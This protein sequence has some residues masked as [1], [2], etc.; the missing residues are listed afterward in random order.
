MGLIRLAMMFMVYISDENSDVRPGQRFKTVFT[1]KNQCIDLLNDGYFE[2]IEPGPLHSPIQRFALRRDETLALTLE[3]EAAPNA[4]STAVPYPSGTVRFNTNQAELV[5]ISG[6]RAVL[7]GVQTR[8]VRRSGGLK[9]IA[10]VH[11]LTATPGDLG[12]TAY[13]IE[14]LENVPASPFFWPDSIRT[15]NETATTSVALAEDCI[16]I[17]GSDR[18][19]SISQAA[20]RLTVAGNTLYLCTFGRDDPG[21]K[22]KSGCV[23]YVGTPDDLT[24]KKI[25][26]ALGFALG[27]Y[28]IEIGHTLYDQ[29]WQIVSAT[30]R[31]AYSLS[32]KAFDL[33][34][35]PLAP[36]SDRKFQYDLGRTKL[37]RMVNALFSAYEMLDLGNLSWAYW[38]ARTATVHIAPA[39]FGAAIEAL[40]RAYIEAHPDTIATTT[41]VRA[42]WKELKDAVDRV[43]AAAIIPEDSKAILSGNVH[44]INRAPQREILKAILRAIDVDLG[45]DENAAWKRRN[46]AAHGIPIPEGEELTAIRD[47]K[48]LMGLFHRMLL[49]ISNASDFYMD[50]VSPCLP[51]RRLKEPPRSMGTTGG[52]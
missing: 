36:L 3:T 33:V 26:T 9:E 49:R 24:R 20:V 30:A 15:V 32:Q 2:F 14:W 6:I 39:H 28:L 11:L 29:G 35:M 4:K 18:R 23:I 22:I 27:V 50:H 21:R 47:M 31:S 42:Q 17:S 40:Q 12:T 5:N 37:T 19:D 1:W 7:S 16:T 13:T 38:H 10:A 44:I 34:P 52:K 8:S 45:A 46:D 48:L 41:V 51:L 25:R 43:I